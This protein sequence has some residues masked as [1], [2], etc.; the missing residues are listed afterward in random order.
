MVSFAAEPIFSVGSFKFTNTLLDTFIIDA[1]IVS[2]CFYISKNIKLIPGK[3]Q[4]G[5]EYITETLYNLTESVAAERTAKIFPYFMSFFLFI[6]LI[7]WSG[8]IPGVGTIGFFH[9]AD[10]KKELIPLVR[11][12]SSD[13][14]MTL[15]LALVSLVATH[16]MSISTVGIK[17]YLSRYFSLNPIFLYVGILEIIGEITKV[18]SLSFRLFGNIFAGE[19]VLSTVSSIYAFLF[20]LPFMLLEVIVGLVQALVF[21][22]LTMAFMAVLTTPHHAPEEVRHK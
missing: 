2:I 11:A 18:I 21:S 17:N 8:L 3:L 13:L 19:V 5:V 20:P 22:M 1:I 9:V 7:N 14:N 12:A 16:L 10:G 6:L 4:N 15:G